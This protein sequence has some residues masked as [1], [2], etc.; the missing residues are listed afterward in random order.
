MA[1][2]IAHL[3]SDD[4]ARRD[5]LGRAARLATQLGQHPRAIALWETRVKAGADDAEA[6]DGLVDLLDRVG[7]SER[8]A[9]VLELRAR[10]STGVESRRADRVRVAKLLGDVIRRPGD[11]IESWRGVERDF[12]DAD[13]AALALSALLRQTARWPELAAMLERRV[14]STAEATTRAELLRQLGDIH[15]NQLGAHEL[16]V[17][18]YARTLEV[19]ARNAGARAGL[20]VL[21]NEGTHRA[22][23]V[24]VLLG[25]LRACDDWQALLELT[26]HRLLAATTDDTK[27]SVLLEAHNNFARCR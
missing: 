11:A 3:E 14:E 5:A 26:S 25:A 24:G 15:R 16:A 2:R 20:Q 7:D 8:L 4:D 12:G 18:T 9:Q 6:L 17:A 21:A 23:A 22:A 19:D 27:L 1:E 13:D 10:S